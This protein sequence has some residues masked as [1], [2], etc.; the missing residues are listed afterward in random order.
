M[1]GV[2][3]SGIPIEADTASL[4]RLARDLSA[5]A[6]EAWAACRASLREAGDIV[7]A[8]ARQRASFST[9]IPGTIHTVS[10]LGV[11]KVRAGGAGAPNAAPI[12]NEG[13]EGVF[14][15]PLWGSWERPEG[16]YKNHGKTWINDDPRNQK[17][18]PF[19]AP[20]LAA[21]SQIVAEKIADA[22][23]AAVVRTI[24]EH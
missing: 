9:R 24:R 12:E 1:A 5:A 13:R 18:R 15:H 10:R 11:V 14:R 2:S 21:K 16:G 20:A 3:H 17:A 19:L 23:N 4:N 22:V 7:A 8:D 6:P